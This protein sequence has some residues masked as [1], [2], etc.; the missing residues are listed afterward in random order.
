MVSEILNGESVDCVQQRHGRTSC[1]RQYD[2]LNPLI[3]W[4]SD[5]QPWASECPDVKNCKWRLNPVWN[6]MLYSCT[7]MATEGVKGQMWQ[8]QAGRTPAIHDY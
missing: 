5:T 3:S 6:R 1:N 8:T 2:V 4:H 7:H